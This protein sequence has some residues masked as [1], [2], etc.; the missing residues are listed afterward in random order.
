MVTHFMSGFY[1]PVVARTFASFGKDHIYLDNHESSEYNRI[2]VKSLDVL[3][4]TTLRAAF[5]V[6]STVCFAYASGFYTIFVTGRTETMFSFNYFGVKMGSSTEYHINMVL[7]MGYAMYF[8]TGI[9]CIQA[10]SLLYENAVETDM[11]LVAASLKDIA[12]GIDTKSLTIDERKAKLLSVLEDTK[13]CNDWIH[14]YNNHVYWGNFLPP[15]IFTYSIGFC[16][17]CQYIV[18]CVV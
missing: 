16:I 7:Q 17:L 3:L 14:M 15:L 4:W 11:M 18:S 8:I 1:H 10:Y 9:I 12:H 13:R 2:C 6:L 5:V